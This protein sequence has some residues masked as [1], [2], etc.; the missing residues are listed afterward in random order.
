[1]PVK[2]PILKRSVKLNGRKTSVSLEKEF[3]DGLREIANDEHTSMSALVDK[4]SQSRNN[5][6]LSSSL[7]LFVLHHVRNRKAKQ[8][9]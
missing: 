7:R 2:T 8:R 6:N 9:L 3:W 5:N 4:I 1:M